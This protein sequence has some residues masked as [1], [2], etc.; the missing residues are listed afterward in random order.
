MRTS[1]LPIAALRNDLL[2][3]TFDAV[4]VN[5]VANHPE[6]RPFIGHTE[7]GDL[8]LS[9]LVRRPENIFL[10]GEHGGFALIWSAPRIHEVHTFIVKSGRGEW[11]REAAAEML[12]FMTS[13]AERLWTRIHSAQ[14]NV[15]R[16]AEEMGMRPTGM[17]IETFGEPHGVYEMVPRCR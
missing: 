2:A 6:V 5:A 1:A 15:I 13:Y 14:V 17:T 4:A 12:E 3:R 16:F 11:A 8:D 9:E 10:I 7:A